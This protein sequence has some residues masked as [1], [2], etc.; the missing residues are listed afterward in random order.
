M[1]E[2]RRLL[3]TESLSKSSFLDFGDVIDMESADTHYAINDGYATRFHDLATVNV[4]AQGGRPIISIFK[5]LPRIFPMQLRVMERHPL[6]SQ[7]FMPMG[8]NHFLVVVAAPTPILDLKTIRCF[9]AKPGQ[10]V[11]FSRGTWHHPLIGL[12]GSTSYLVVDRGGSLGDDNLD[13]I[14]IMSNEVWISAAIETPG[15]RSV[16]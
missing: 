8:D 16:F 14:N 3:P 1:S 12:E 13:E 9:L 10:G 15:S 6:G 4:G 7:A 11:N 2:V 5:T